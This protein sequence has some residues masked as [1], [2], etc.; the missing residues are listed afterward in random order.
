[1][2]RLLLPVGLLEALRVELPALGRPDAIGTR[3]LGGR[4]RVIFGLS[5]L[6]VFS[7]KILNFYFNI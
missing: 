5:S 1:M 4:P 2:F 3:V 7:L 6:T